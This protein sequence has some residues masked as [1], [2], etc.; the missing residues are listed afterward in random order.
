M[1]SELMSRHDMGKMMTHY[2]NRSFHLEEAIERAHELHKE[3]PGPSDD[4]MCSHC[5][6]DEYRYYEYPCPTIKALDGEQ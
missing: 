2:I 6:V 3:V 5:Y 1:S 4:T